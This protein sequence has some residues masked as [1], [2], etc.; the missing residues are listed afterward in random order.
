[1]Y[2]RFSDL[3]HF[4]L[5]SC[6]FLIGGMLGGLNHVLAVIV[7]QDIGAKLAKKGKASSISTVTGVIDGIGSLGSTVG[8]ALIGYTSTKWG[9]KNGYLLV[10][11]FMISLVL[12]PMIVMFIKEF[13]EI[14]EIR[15]I[16]R[17]DKQNV[18]PSLEF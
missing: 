18:G 15:K 9:W 2:A 5:G 17:K 11:T 14:I 16:N 1:M 12:I 13:K 3:T 10:F 7:A 8:S 4:E 6:L